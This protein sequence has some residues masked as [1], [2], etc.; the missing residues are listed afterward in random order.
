ML[1]ETSSS[2][3]SRIGVGVSSNATIGCRLPLMREPRS[4]RGVSVGTSRPAPSVTVTNTRTD[5][6]RC[7]HRWV[8]AALSAEPRIQNK[9]E[10]TAT[11]GVSASVLSGLLHGVDYEHID[12]TAN[13]FSLKTELTSQSISERRQCGVGRGASGDR[14]MPKALPSS[15]ERY[16]TIIERST[17]ASPVDDRRTQIAR[18]NVART[19]IAPHPLLVIAPVGMGGCFGPVRTSHCLG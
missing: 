8:L 14:L 2:K 7:E 16:I 15:G 5:R 3:T 17:D 18:G 4:A 6:C 19:D 12:R 9:D 11:H 10:N 13:T 1:P